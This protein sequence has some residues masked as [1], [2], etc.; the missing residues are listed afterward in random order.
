MYRQSARP[1]PRARTLT[2]TDRAL[3]VQ[4][5]AG[6]FF[7]GV[8]SCPVVDLGVLR[9]ALGPFAGVPFI[10][11]L[12]AITYAVMCRGTRTRVV[13]DPVAD[14]LRVEQDNVGSTWVRRV[15]LAAPVYAGETSHA[16]VDL[17][18]KR[19]VHAA[20]LYDAQGRGL[21]PVAS[22]GSSSET[23]A[24]ARELNEALRSYAEERAG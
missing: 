5:A 10:L 21:L 14:E 1:T 23:A 3:A 13:L 15:S 18:K 6:V 4:A 22:G 17:G 2:W 19:V 11:L 24:F 12:A 16:T 7:L 9:D 8:T 20:W